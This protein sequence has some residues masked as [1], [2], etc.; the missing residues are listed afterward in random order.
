VVEPVG[1]GFACLAAGV[2]RPD[3]TDLAP[4][5]AHIHTQLTAL[6]H[7]FIPDVMVVED[8]Y[9]DY[10]YPRTAI[11]MGH[12]RGVI[13]LAA[14]LRAVPVVSYGAAEVKRAVTGNGRASKAQVQSLVQRLLQLPALPTPDHVSDALALAICHTYRERLSAQSGGVIGLHGRSATK[15]PRRSV[16][17]PRE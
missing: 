3:S 17:R 15:A 10:E 16:R 2:I 9:A 7:E 11:L 13:F 12:A 1:T 4:R 8:L 5:L 6:L 14:A